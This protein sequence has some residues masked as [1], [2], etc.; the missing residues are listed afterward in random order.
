MKLFTIYS[1]SHADLMFDFLMPSVKAFDVFGQRVTQLCSSGIYRTPGWKEMISQKT[2]A[3]VK[4]CRDEKEP[5]V[6]T[7]ADVICH[8]FTPEDA[9]E[10]LGD[11]D[12]ACIDDGGGVFCAGFMIVRPC[13]STLALFERTLDTLVEC[14]QPAMNA[15]IA[16][17]E[18]K[19]KT[20][21]Q[22]RY[23]NYNLLGAPD[24]TDDTLLRLLKLPDTTKV[25]HANW[26]VGLDRKHEALKIVRNLMGKR[27]ACNPDVAGVKPA[28]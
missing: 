10:D 1:P 25:F 2:G 20:L 24:W 22:E 18:P 27:H 9:V 11:A 8:D 19:A 28:L 7:D 21:P 6:Y 26:L 23:T 12:L 14:E 5:F 13:A 15:A 17:L 3:L 16:Q 4:C